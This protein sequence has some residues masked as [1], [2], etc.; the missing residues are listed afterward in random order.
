MGCCCCL[1]TTAVVD[2]AGKS[3]VNIVAVAVDV[4][5]EIDKNKFDFD[6]D[7]KCNLSHT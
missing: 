7:S 3:V 4:A 2:I 1:R 6:L 5:G